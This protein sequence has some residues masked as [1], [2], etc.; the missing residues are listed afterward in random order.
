V[1]RPDKQAAAASNRRS[2]ERPADDCLV[3]HTRHDDGHEIL[4]TPLNLHRSYPALSL[5]DQRFPLCSSIQ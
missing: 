3:R 4:S 5:A 2:E 1:C